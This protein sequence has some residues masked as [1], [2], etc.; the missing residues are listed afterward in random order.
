MAR[1]SP[2]MSLDLDWGAGRSLIWVDGA[3]SA[4]AG[5]IILMDDPKAQPVHC[6]LGKSVH[7]D[8]HRFINDLE[9]WYGKEIIRIRNERYEM[10][11]EVFEDRRYLSGINGAPCTSEMKFVP[12]MDFQLPSDTHFWGYT[13][14]K[15]DAARFDRMITDYPL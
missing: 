15:R 4:V 13:A 1:G 14:D 7:P 10:I 11:D 3:N 2:Q 12:R 5:H 9:Q 8:N 6:D